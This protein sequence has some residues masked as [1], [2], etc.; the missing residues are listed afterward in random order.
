MLQSWRSISGVRRRRRRARDDGGASALFPSSPLA[1]SALSSLPAP[2]SLSR[3]ARSAARRGRSTQVT[4][5]EAKDIIFSDDSRRAIQRG[6]DKLADAVG[7]TLGPRGAPPK[8]YL[9]RGPGLQLPSPCSSLRPPVLSAPSFATKVDACDGRGLPESA[10][11]RCADATL[12]DATHSPHLA[13]R[14]QKR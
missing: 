6:I 1:M 12:A 9:L 5:A 14:V 3:P 8:P 7:V 2:S 11:S 4:R 10:L 13:A